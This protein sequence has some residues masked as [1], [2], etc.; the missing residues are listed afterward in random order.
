MPN[1]CGAAT[2]NHILTDRRFGGSIITGPDVGCFTGVG[3]FVNNLEIVE[4]LVVS[5]GTGMYQNIV[6][7]SAVTLTGRL[8][9]KTGVNRFQVTPDPDDKVCFSTP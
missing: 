7:G 6:P 1:A 5:G 4:R 2:A 8:G 9:L 3:D